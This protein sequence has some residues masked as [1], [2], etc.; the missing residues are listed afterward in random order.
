MSLI[1]AADTGGTFTDLAAFD[2]ESG[3]IRYAKS[4]TTYGDLV[5]GLLD[6]IRKAE[7]NLADVDLIKFGTTLVINTYVQ[8]NGSRTA[9]VTTQ[10]FRD[11]LELRRGNRASPFDIRYA[12]H[13]PLVPRELRLE[14]NERLAADGSILQPLDDTEI[15]A[16]AAVLRDLKVEAVAVSLFNSYVDPS[17]EQ[18]LAE[19]LRSELPDVYVTAGT[20]I[21]RE[22]YEYERTSTAVANAYVG[23]K[24]KDYVDRLDNALRDGGFTRS[25]YLMASNGGVASVERAQ[26]RPVTLVESGPVGGIIGAAAYGAD[27]G[28]NKLV[29]F[30]MGGTTAKCAVIEDGRFAV[31][32]PYYVGGSEYGFP[33][34]GG[35]LDIIEVGAGGGSIAGVD[36]VGRLLVG[37]RSAG[38]EPGPI[39]YG[40]GGIEPT[41]TDANLVLGRIGEQSFLGGDM[42][43]D[44]AAA[45]EGIN[46][47][48]ERVGLV[49]ESRM[50]EMASGILALAALTMSAAVRTITI[51]RGLD[52]RD[53]AMVSFGGGGP[54][55]SPAIARELGMKM[56]VI[57]PEPG[58]FSA[59][60][61]IL[62]D[63][64]IDENETFVRPFSVESLIDIMSA[65]E[66]MQQRLADELGREVE[67]GTVEFEHHVEIRYRGQQHSLRIE[68]GIDWTLDRI[69]TVYHAAYLARFGHV[70]EQQSLEFVGLVVA[71][72][73]RLH[74]LTPADFIANAPEAGRSVSHDTRPIY[75]GEVKRRM[76]S[77]VY[78]RSDLPIGFAARGPA[79]IEEYGSTTLVGP[80]DRFEIGE[81]LEIRVLFDA[82]EEQYDAA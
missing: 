69:R 12:R 16:T 38:S 57:P 28:L 71:A 14:V 56:V 49:G 44:L 82:I 47:L 42:S 19:R 29:G 50:D 26:R 33:V 51:E 21:S 40:K 17:T 46:Q 5:T 74:R 58:V 4:L 53:F 6:C 30:D 3:E 45:R 25:F 81:F 75:F 41:I 54:L 79:V 43:L 9:L 34:R 37:P 73:A 70:D 64:R 36:N 2:T 66:S 11:T 65:F 35:V 7:I 80:F 59:M 8:Q 78:R 77:A 22:W 39:C 1:V 48:A 76:D 24:L 15:A 13:A 55:H 52:P 60:G 67:G 18:R 23:P 63:A 10:G 20:D 62:S 32:S 27:L 61:M 68:I 31:K 72:T